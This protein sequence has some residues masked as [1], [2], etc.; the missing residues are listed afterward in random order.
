M[1]GPRSRP[2]SSLRLLVTRDFGLL[3][4]GETLSQIGDSLNR[5]ALLWFA[6]QTSHSTLRMSIV[7]VLQTLPALLLGPVIGVYLDRLRKKPALIVVSLV[8]A[9]LIS[10]IPILHAAHLLSL[11]LLYVFVLVLSVVG[12]VAGPALSTA[13]PLL[14][15]R[16]DLTGANALIQGAA[17]I[18]VL[19][20]PAVAGVAIALFGISRVL[21]IDAASFVAFAACVALIRLPERELT[22][23]LPLRLRE[24]ARELHAGLVFLG[25]QQTGILFLTL[26]TGLQNIGASAFVFML[27]A[28][29]KKD[30]E[31][32]S[33]WLGLLWSA[34][35]LGMLLASV[36]LAMVGRTR[37]SSLL[38]LA[39]IALVLGALSIVALSFVKVKLAAATLMVVIG[40]SAAAFNP[41][42]ISLVTGGTPVDL[43]ARVLT[44]F[45]SANMAAVTVGMLAFGWA[46]DRLGTDLTLRGIASVLLV[47]ALALGTVMR[48]QSTR[49]LVEDLAVGP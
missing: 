42:V 24:L 15:S 3:W 7:G 10:T 22:P 11:D 13:V 19:L 45:S 35:G 4:L 16:A 49:R 44:A 41:V 8:R 18:G 14:V 5:V 23:R 27:P 17:T 20:G 47:S 48:V 32:G 38:R 46:A 39:L 21:Y 40:W 31:A 30:V 33:V 1:T 29:V 25:R 9:A 2:T 12:T 34:F 28:F 37:I 6:Y 43:R 36:S 26:V